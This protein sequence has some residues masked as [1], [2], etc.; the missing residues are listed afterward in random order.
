MHNLLSK[1]LISKTEKKNN[2][3]SQR[4][5]HK[6]RPSL[7]RKVHLLM[8]FSISNFKICSFVSISFSLL[9]ASLS[10]FFPFRLPHF[11]F[12]LLLHTLEKIL[13]EVKGRR[14]EEYIRSKELGKRISTSSNF[15]LIQSMV[16]K[17]LGEISLQ[18]KSKPHL[19]SHYTNTHSPSSSFAPMQWTHPTSYT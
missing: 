13:Q 10:P 14:L 11:S 9:I 16:P 17:C 8:I 12:L 5:D 4:A 1:G 2:A 7:P 3:R 19:H 18:T 15:L 6:N